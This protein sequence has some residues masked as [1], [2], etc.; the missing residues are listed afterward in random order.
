MLHGPV[1]AEERKLFV[2]MIARTT[3]EDEL[4]TMFAPFGNI[5]EL[6]VLRGADG[7]GKGC[8]FVKYH[9]RQEAHSAAQVLHNSMTVPVR[10]Q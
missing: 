9:T 7:A 4:R 3:T 2:G 5:E 6:A 10:R 1:A 8:A